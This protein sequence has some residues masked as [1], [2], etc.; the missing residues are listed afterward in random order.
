M[1]RYIIVSLVIAMSGTVQAKPA[2]VKTFEAK[3]LKQLVVRNRT[4]GDIKIQAYDTPNIVGI[5]DNETKNQACTADFKQSENQLTV[6][7]TAGNARCKLN[8][9]FKVPQQIA[10]QLLTGAGDIEVKGTHGSLDLKV[11]SGDIII[12]A[13][14]TRLDSMTGSG[15][16]QAQGLA[17]DA[18]IRT[19]SGS[20]ELTYTTVP[21]V[22]SLN[23]RTGSGKVEIKLPK[24]SKILTNYLT[25][26]GEMHS[27]ISNSQDAQFKLDVRTGSGDLSI[28]RN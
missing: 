11:G 12:N 17:G 14:V 21:S 19:G 8:L 4:G 6:E 16:I 7:T 22:G 9:K 26:S 1:L 2:I 5:V 25:G 10:L 18:I 24:D 27:D 13:T 15:D 23:V 20:V 3:N 28:Y